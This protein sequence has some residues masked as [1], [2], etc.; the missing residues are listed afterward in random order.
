MDATSR[1]LTQGQANQQESREL[2]LGVCGVGNKHMSETTGNQNGAQLSPSTRQTRSICGFIFPIS[3][4]RI[5]TA[6]GKMS[7]EKELNLPEM[8][9]KEVLEMC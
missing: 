7:P 2:P 5:K 3:Y 6:F 8:Q 4:V 9:A 1:E